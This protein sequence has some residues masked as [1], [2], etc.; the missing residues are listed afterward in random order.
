METNDKK[1]KYVWD[2]ETSGLDGITDKISCISILNLTTNDITSFYGPN[3]TKI[4]KDFWKKISWTS[5]IIGFNIVFDLPFLIQRTLINNVPVCVNYSNIR[6][7]DIR[8]LSMAFFEVYKRTIKGT[9][10]QW[11]EHLGLGNKKTSG[12]EM[13]NFYK[14][15]EWEK[16]KKHCENDVIITSKLY[17]RLINCG[18]IKKQNI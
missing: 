17:W 9:L 8:L 13:I 2:I 3:E 18:I 12:D 5:E 15:K 11:S 4:L 6:K 1:I 16:I 7:T 14:N 10:D